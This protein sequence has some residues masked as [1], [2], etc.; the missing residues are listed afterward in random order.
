M[1]S[2][3]VGGD[4]CGLSGD[5]GPAA[6]ALFRQPYDICRD[7]I[8]NL[9]VCDLDNDR[10]RKINAM[11]SVITTIA[12]GGS[13]VSESVQATA[14]LLHKPTGA[15][16]DKTGNILIVEG[17]GA[18]VRKVNVT[19]GI[20]T[21][22]AGTGINSFSG[23]GG[24]ATN[25][26]LNHPFGVCIDTSGNIYITDGGVRIRR[27][28][29]STGFISTIAGTGVSGYSGDGGPATSAKL[30]ANGICVDTSGDVYFTDGAY[31]TMRKINSATGIITTVAGTGVSGNTGVGGPATAAE[32]TNPYRVIIDDSSNLLIADGNRIC[33]VNAANGILTVFAGAHPTTSGTEGDGGQADSAA[34]TSTGMCFDTCGNLYLSDAGRCRIRVIT[35]GNTEHLCGFPNEVPEPM[36]PAAVFRIYPNPAANTLNI[37]NPDAEQYVIRDMLGRELK[38]GSMSAGEVVVDVQRLARGSYIFTA[39]KSNI[40]C[41]SGVFVKE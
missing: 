11:T 17:T 4:S 41:F 40:R 3:S 32:L 6:H 20:I 24:P 7:N 37:L 18:K 39:F 12:G 28:S 10:I 35:P 2:V 25:A 8:G 31:F 22:I 5:G 1:R 19:T 27:I 15:C 14:T 34:M 26:S 30:W 21:T 16:I 29:S 23:D 13:L 33:K 9:Y 38:R 36:P